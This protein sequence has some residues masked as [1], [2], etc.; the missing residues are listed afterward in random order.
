MAMN[1]KEY[2]KEVGMVASIMADFISEKLYKRMQEKGQG[3]V[4]K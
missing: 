3:Y 4:A 1:K 2:A